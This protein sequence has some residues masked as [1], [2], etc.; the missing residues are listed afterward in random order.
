MCP[1]EISKSELQKTLIRKGM[2]IVPIYK[3]TK[4]PAFSHPSRRSDKRPWPILCEE[5]KGTEWDMDK[6]D[7]G[8]K[9]TKI[10]ED[11]YFMWMDIDFHDSKDKDVFVT[12]IMPKLQNKGFLVTQSP[13]G[14]YHYGFVTDYEAK[15]RTIVWQLPGSNISVDYRTMGA[16]C[17][18]LDEKKT[19]SV[20]EIPDRIIWMKWDDFNKLMKDILGFRSK[21]EDKDSRHVD[22]QQRELI[23]DYIN[24][25]KVPE[26]ITANDFLLA[27]IKY[28]MGKETNKVEILQECNQL[29]SKHFP[30]SSWTNNDSKVIAKIDTCFEEQKPLYLEKGRPKGGNSSG[31]GASK[32]AKEVLDS[33]RLYSDKSIRKLYITENGFL[34]DTTIE[35]ESILAREYETDRSTTGEVIHFLIAF[36]EDLPETSANKIRFKNGAFDTKVNEF[37]PNDEELCL[38]GYPNYNY[39]ENPNPSRFIN[40]INNQVHD[41]SKRNLNAWLKKAPTASKEIRMAVFYGLPGCGK[42][43]LAETIE[44]TLGDYGMGVRMKDYISDRPTQSQIVGKTMLY[45]QDTE[46]SWDD[47]DILKQITGESKLNTRG[48]YQSS[49]MAKNMLSI[50]MSTNNLVKIAPED[51]GPMYDRIALVKFNDIKI[52]GTDKDDE[53]F[54]TTLAEEEGEQII[55]YCLNLRKNDDK[56]YTSEETKQQWREISCPEEALFKRLFYYKKD[57]EGM[58][59]MDTKIYME[60]S[61]NI[62]IEDMDALKKILKNSGYSITRGLYQ[63]LAKKEI[64]EGSLEEYN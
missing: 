13:S 61:S 4:A 14:G 16:Q 38:I 5:A 52:R 24:N 60:E 9:G 22:N 30:D 18:V 63:G 64:K 51:E 39:I 37:L 35:M 19:Y 25:D 62:E 47:I 33:H 41:D 23:I 8:V 1:I 48:M 36:A 59:L 49:Q 42:T 27:F 12:T 11:K 50:C 54:P 34:Q 31:G 44:F 6:Y 43:A 57:E 2:C 21:Y 10:D 58:S 40:M 32:I 53:E 55:S 7:L 3:G 28:H 17:V 15:S 20:I 29:L 45:F 26:D 56:F 46:K